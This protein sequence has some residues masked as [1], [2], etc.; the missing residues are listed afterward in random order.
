[1]VKDVLPRHH[2]GMSLMS[3]YVIMSSFLLMIVGTVYCIN[4]NTTW[5]VNTIALLNIFIAYKLAASKK[6]KH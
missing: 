5:P 2:Y 4:N 6:K 1:M 3:Q